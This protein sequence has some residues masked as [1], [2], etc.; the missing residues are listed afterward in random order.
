MKPA[1]QI[2]GDRNASVQDPVGNRWWIATHQEDVSP[3][4][5]M[6]RAQALQ[7]P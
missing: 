6:K 4:E 1:D 3:E 7:Q 2:Y 5:F